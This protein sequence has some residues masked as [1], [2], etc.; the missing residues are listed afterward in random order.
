M[1]GLCDCIL[2]AF[3]H[4]ACA[5]HLSPQYQ[6]LATYFVSNA[7]IRARL[8][9]S[10]PMSQLCG[11]GRRGECTQ[12]SR[13]NGFEHYNDSVLHQTTAAEEHELSTPLVTNSL[14]LKVM[15]HCKLARMLRDWL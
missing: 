3:T 11:G 1:S 5:C 4:H 14:F 8:L 15:L 2:L 9:H 12:W 13:L 7:W 10:F 6:F